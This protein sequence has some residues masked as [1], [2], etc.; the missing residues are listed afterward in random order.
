MCFLGQR[1]KAFAAFL[2]FMEHLEEC[3]NVNFSCETR[4]LNC[5]ECILVI[6]LNMYF[7]FTVLGIIKD[8]FS[9]LKSTLL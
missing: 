7:Y 6:Y 4:V 9:L 3:A 1:I 8:H 5:T 2:Y